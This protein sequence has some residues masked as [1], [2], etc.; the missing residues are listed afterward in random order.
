MIASCFVHLLMVSLS[1]TQTRRGE[2]KPCKPRNGDSLRRQSKPITNQ[3]HSTKLQ[4]HPVPNPQKH[5][6]TDLQ[7]LYLFYTLAGP[8]V[9][10]MVQD[11]LAVTHLDNQLYI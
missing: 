3:H 4:D 6:K 9:T 10:R 1:S 2:N 11:P 5:N 8:T 7:A